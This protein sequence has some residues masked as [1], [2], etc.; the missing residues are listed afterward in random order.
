MTHKIIDIRHGKDLYVH[1]AHLSAT[2]GLLFR[3]VNKKT[4]LETDTMFS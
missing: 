4:T 1:L 3:M 2:M